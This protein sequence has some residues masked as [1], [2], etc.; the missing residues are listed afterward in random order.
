MA[1]RALLH[2]PSDVVAD[3]QGVLYIADSGNHVIRRIIPGTGIID[4]Y[5]KAIR[6]DTTL[7]HSP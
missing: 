3:R 5:G 1:T 4:T 7:T 6:H 2:S